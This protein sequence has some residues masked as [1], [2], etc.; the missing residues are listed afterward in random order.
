ME[1]PVRCCDVLRDSRRVG[2]GPGHRR[3]SPDGCEIILGDGCG[4]SGCVNR[5][6]RCESAQKHS[7][8]SRTER[9]ELR[10]TEVDSRGFVGEGRGARSGNDICESRPLTKFRRSMLVYRDRRGPKCPSHFRCLGGYN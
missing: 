1:G 6:V 5:R 8:Q 9:L 4:I 7:R 3:G 2:R 10:I